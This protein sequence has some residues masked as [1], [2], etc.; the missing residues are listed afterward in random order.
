[1]KRKFLATYIRLLLGSAFFIF[2]LNGFLSFIPIPPARPAAERLIH[3]IVETG[4]FFGM[5]KS[6]EITCGVLLL[7][8]RFVPLALIL[9]SPLLVGITSIHLFLNPE[10]LPLMGILLLLHGYLV[11][12][13]WRHF[14]ALLV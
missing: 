3:A 10:G 7:T 13:Y 6:I 12:H 1:M 14:Q 5:V 4:Y 9:L 11:R 2:G 8:N